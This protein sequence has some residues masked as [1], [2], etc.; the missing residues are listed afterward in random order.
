MSKR[1]IFLK[2]EE[3]FNYISYASYTDAKLK[4]SPIDE[5]TGD[6]YTSFQTSV[7]Y[8]FNFNMYDTIYEFGHERL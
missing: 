1:C 4:D 6:S 5:R 8:A 3:N 7:L 2:F